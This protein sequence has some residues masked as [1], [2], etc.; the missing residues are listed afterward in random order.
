MVQ[1]EITFKNLPKTVS[2]L[3]TEVA[4]IKNLACKGLKSITP[5]QRIPIG[6]DDAC[7]LIGKAKTQFTP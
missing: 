5:P 6:I 1:N 3:V 7:K 4:E 2:H